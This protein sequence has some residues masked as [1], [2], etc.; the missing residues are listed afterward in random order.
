MVHGRLRR[1][2]RRTQTRR[3]WERWLKVAL[4]VLPRTVADMLLLLAWRRHIGRGDPDG[5]VD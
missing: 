5:P 1:D 2:L 4:A 3:I